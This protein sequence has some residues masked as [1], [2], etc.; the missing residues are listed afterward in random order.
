M[1]SS[2]AA[3]RELNLWPCRDRAVIPVPAPAIPRPSIV[4]MVMVVRGSLLT[5]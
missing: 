5:L 3:L 4:A 1:S 2:M